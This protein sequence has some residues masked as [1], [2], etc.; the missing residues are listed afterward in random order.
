MPGRSPAEGNDR[1]FSACAYMHCGTEQ[2]PGGLS[3]APVW[4]D[5]E[6]VVSV[7]HSDASTIREH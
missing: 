6:Q 3:M 5:G 1:D 7:R 2:L 4:L